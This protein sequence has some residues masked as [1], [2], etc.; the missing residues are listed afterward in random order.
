[1]LLE[2]SYFN[3]VKYFAKAQLSAFLGGIVDFLVM[4]SCVELFSRSY[5]EGIIIGGLI[6]AVVN[7]SINKYWTFNKD[8]KQVS[9]NA[10]FKFL[11]VLLG[12]IVLK[13]AGTYFF[14]EIVQVDYKISRLI[15]DAF[16]AFG[17]NYTLQRLWVF[18]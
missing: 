7:Y 12:C 17:F 11:F 9:Q 4:V 14:T 16:V 18:K 15:T 3:E 13:S 10:F 8:K 6:G 5:I 2:R 1:M